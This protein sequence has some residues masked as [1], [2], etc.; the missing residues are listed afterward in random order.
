MCGRYFWTHDAEDALEEDFPE[1]VG[2]ILQQADSLR[3]GDYTPAMKAMALVGGASSG[4]ASGTGSIASGNANG[5]LADITGRESG[6][7]RRELTPQVL[8]WGFPGF[9][10]GKLLINA[11]AESVKDRPT[12]QKL[13]TGTMRP[14]GSGLLRV[15]PEQ[16]EGHVYGSGQAHLISGRNLEAL[17]PRKAICDP[18]QGS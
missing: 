18:D 14:A 17:R 15:G 5:S 1:L 16:R 6:S 2:Q 13:R 4:P 3:A 7:P 12:L 8:Q 11:R 10:K 9:D